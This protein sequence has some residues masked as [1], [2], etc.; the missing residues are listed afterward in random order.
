MTSVAIRS[1]SKW[2]G[3]FQALDSLDVSIESGELFFLLG[4][5]GCG[6]STLLRLIAGLD[7]CD[8]GEILFDGKNVSAL[9]TEQRNIGMVFQ[10]YALWPH[11]T[12]AENVL[13]PLQSRN[14]FAGEQAE[15]VR[16]ALSLVQCEALAAR[17]PGELSG[18]QQQRVALARA[19][20]SEPVLLL[21]DEPLSNLDARLRDELREEIRKL[22]ERL[23]I[24]TIFVTHDQSEALSLASRILLMNAGTISQLGTPEDL[25]FHPQNRFAAAFIGDA[26]I[27]EAAAIDA[28]FAR[29]AI[30]RLPV[31]MP[32]AAGSTLLCLRPEQL[33]VSTAGTGA[34]ARVEA[35]LFEGGQRTLILSA[36]NNVRL[37]ARSLA[38]EPFSVGQQVQVTVE[39]AVSAVAA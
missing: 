24:T 14:L 1:V 8:A 34:Q 39:G 37:T 16:A 31:T 29:T 25:Y 21:L 9:P 20:V 13:F 2:F 33:R 30:G 10:A 19:I 11:L 27:I 28:G 15:R 3:S 5:S 23:R 12:V 7:R 32:V 22:H 26:N 4:P 17:F 18:G 36:D 38:A 6:K 35:V